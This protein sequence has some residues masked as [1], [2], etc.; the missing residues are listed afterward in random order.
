MKNMKNIR[1]DTEKEGVFEE[2]KINLESFLEV[3]GSEIQSLIKICKQR[4]IAVTK[5]KLNTNPSNQYE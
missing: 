3:M 1:K 5:E 4:M 2:N